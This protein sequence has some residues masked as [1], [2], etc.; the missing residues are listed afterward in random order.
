[1]TIVVSSL[2]QEKVFDEK[3]DAINIGTHPECNFK[4]ELDFDVYLGLDY[5]EKYRA[6]PYIGVLKPEIYE[7]N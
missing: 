3:K 7:N 6:L 4:L 2:K 5:D 1:M